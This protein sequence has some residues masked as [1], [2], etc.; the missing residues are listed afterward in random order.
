MATFNE[1]ASS[2]ALVGS[3]LVARMPDEEGRMKDTEID[4]DECI[5]NSNGTSL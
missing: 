1:D 3:Y 2:I 4:L 5:G